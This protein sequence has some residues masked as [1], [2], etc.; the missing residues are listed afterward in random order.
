MRDPYEVA[1]FRFEMISCLLDDTL[2][3][4]ERQRLIKQRVSAPVEWPDGKTCPIPRATLYRWYRTFRETLKLESLLPT[5]RSG[6]GSLRDQRAAWVEKAVHLLI[7]Q[8]RRSLTL[9]LVFLRAYF[10]DHQLTKSSLDRDLRAH[11][12]WPAIRR[13]RGKLKR[14]RTRFEAREPHHIWQIDA[15]GAFRVRLTSGEV[16][17]VVALTILDDNTRAVL[18]VVIARTESL[19]PAVRLFR[20]V[21][22]RWGLP[23]RLYADRGSVYESLAFR[24][25]LAELGVHRIWTKSKNPQA[26]GKIEAYHRTLKR[27][28]V[29]ELPTQEVVDLVHLE[30]LLQAVIEIVYQP[31]PHRSLRT[32]PAAA[33]NQRRS[34]R[35]VSVQ[36]LQRA[37]WVSETRHAHPATGEVNLNG[38]VFR[39]PSNYAGKRVRLRYD[40]ADPRRVVLVLAT[41]A[42]TPLEIFGREPGRVPADSGPTRWGAGPLQKLLDTYNG[43]TRPNA[44]AGFGLPEV[45]DA[46]GKA[47]GHGIPRT[48]AEALAIQGFFREHG[49]FRAA[50]FQAALDSTMAV[51]GPGRPVQTILDHL[52]RLVVA[53]TKDESTKEDECS[54]KSPTSSTTSP[55]PQTKSS[56]RRDGACATRS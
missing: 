32:S 42:E 15:K 51:L 54:A 28:F 35:E 40:P 21:A 52:H 1:T 55:R 50:A 56:R 9:V 47:L 44:D 4:A 36:D 31:H 33:L 43:R 5:R 37:F 7:E 30:Q 6:Q 16:V 41:G 27:W 53:A 45:F 18:G 12:L 26:H 29:D 3:P 22:A 14:L 34:G 2:T 20:D 13:M 24:R 25:G 38:A 49:P 11:A 23:A 10:P 8:P 48:E 46:L 17:S 19:G 39:A